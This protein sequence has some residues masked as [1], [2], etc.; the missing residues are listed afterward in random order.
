MTI[1]NDLLAAK[2][3]VQENDLIGG[4]CA[5]TSDDPPSEQKGFPVA[6]F[7]T[8]EIAKHIVSVHNNWLALRSLSENFKNFANSINKIVEDY[9]RSKQESPK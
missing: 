6:D 4:W 9:N 8:E 5:M 2:W 3:Y 1:D 7:L